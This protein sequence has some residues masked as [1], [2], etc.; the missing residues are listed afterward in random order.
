[1]WCA[2][3][4]S[5]TWCKIDVILNKQSLGFQNISEYIVILTINTISKL[6]K[7]WWEDSSKWILWTL[8]TFFSKSWLGDRQ[9]IMWYIIFIFWE[10]QNVF[11]GQS[12]WYICI[13]SDIW[14]ASS[15]EDHELLDYISQN[16]PN[17]LVI[18][19][20]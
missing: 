5:V 3:S 20:F 1:M 6:V 17:T 7:A 13:A 9:Y 16:P 15:S 10:T 14:L 4:K 19:I 2:L 11:W 18:L 8:K 12:D